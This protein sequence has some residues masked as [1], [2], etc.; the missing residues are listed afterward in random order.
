MLPVYEGEIQ[1]ICLGSE[2]CYRLLRRL[3]LA[4]LSLISF[5]PFPITRASRSSHTVAIS[6]FSE[7]GVAL[8]A[9]SQGDLVCTKSFPCMPAFF[10]GD[11]GGKRYYASYFDKF[12]G[13]WAH[14]DFCIITGSQAGNGGGL[15]MLGRSDG[16]LNRKLFLV[17]LGIFL[18]G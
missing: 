18:K 9:D 8:P 10:W 1:C 3:N 2:S 6:S 14:G 13:V 4:G 15:L 12:D 17:C 7:E 5:P 16:V 11:E